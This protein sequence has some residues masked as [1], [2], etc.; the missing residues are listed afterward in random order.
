[1]SPFSD[2]LKNITGDLF[3]PKGGSVIGLDVS[4]STIKVVQLGRKHGRAVLETYGEL[5]LGPYAGVDSGK[6]TNLSAE[7]L[8][9]AVADLMKESKVS[10]NLCGVAIPLSASLI[11]VIE[12]PDVGEARLH[13]MVPIELRKYV[14]VSINEVMIDWR[15]VPKVEAQDRTEQP[16][17]DTKIKKVEILAVAIHKETIEK[18]NTVVQKANLNASFFEIE[19]FSTIRAALEEELAPTMILGLGAATTKI[20]IVDRK[21]LRESHVISRG[22]QEITLALTKG[23]GIDEKK[24]DEMKRTYGVIKEGPN[25][26]VGQIVS[27][28]VDSIF[29]EA[30]HIMLSYQRKHARNIGR[31]ILTGGG[32]VI[33][34]MNERA[35]DIFQAD[36]SVSNP[37]RKVESPAFLEEVLRK[38]GPEFDV[39]VG[40]ALRRLEEQG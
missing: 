1:M 26:D 36:I 38:V 16:V 8:G 13:E 28:V 4:S 30:Q 5:A 27:I 25:A 34:G 12:M 20:Y 17:D 7:K 11:N 19:V 37:F 24:A 40:V 35:R 15:I 23:L 22:S 3:K 6:A 18:Y 32:V 21:V 31:V 2:I 14:P 29:A 33:P 10:T 39:A 9:E